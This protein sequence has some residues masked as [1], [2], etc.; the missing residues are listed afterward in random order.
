M[1]TKQ[2]EEQTKGYGQILSCIVRLD[3]SGAS[4]GYG[5][6][7]YEAE[8]SAKKAIEGLNGKD[9][10]GSVWSVSEFVPRKNRALAQKKKCVC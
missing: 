10:F 1:T 3:E 4:L 2:L 9:L 6:V 8:E 7:Q 5:Y